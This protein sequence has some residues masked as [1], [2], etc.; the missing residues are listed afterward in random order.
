MEEVAGRRWVGGA[1]T[2][3]WGGGPRGSCEVQVE[4]CCSGD[5]AG[6]TPGGL[7]LRGPGGQS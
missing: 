2:L 5:R 1:W 7:A 6:G 4:G 3:S